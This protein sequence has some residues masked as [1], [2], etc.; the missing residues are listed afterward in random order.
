MTWLSENLPT[1]IP[2]ATGVAAALV[3]AVRAV[4]TALVTAPKLEWA[5]ERVILRQEN[6]R[7]EKQISE[8]A[9]ELRELYKSSSR[10]QGK[11]DAKFGSD[12]NPP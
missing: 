11:Y 12:S 2:L 9:R 1:V 4:W 7:L 10:L 5:A 3:A 6:E 8:L